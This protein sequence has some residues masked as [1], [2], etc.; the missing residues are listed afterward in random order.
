[1]QIWWPLTAKC[2]VNATRASASNAAR[3]ER[4]AHPGVRARARGKCRV[5]IIQVCAHH[6]AQRRVRL[7][8]A[9]MYGQSVIL[10][11]C[12]MSAVLALPR[13]K[14][15][16]VEAK[17]A[18]PKCVLTLTSCQ[19]VSRRALLKGG[20]QCTS[21]RT[22]QRT[23]ISRGGVSGCFLQRPLDGREIQGLNFGAVKLNSGT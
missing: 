6:A 22:M 16:I 17:A 9:I 7:G 18:K 10:I 14:P 11:G 3:I 15:V 8:D 13:I 12:A 23:L 2:L 19:I 5:V 4:I 20:A 21:R 1:M